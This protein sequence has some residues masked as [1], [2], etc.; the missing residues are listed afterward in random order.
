M[1]HVRERG[2]TAGA[3]LVGALLAGSQVVAQGAPGAA[4]GASGMDAFF[5]GTLQIE[6]P[7]TYNPYFAQRQFSPDH[8]YVDLEDGKLF[9]GTWAI[10]DGKICTTR[11]SGKTF[12]NLGVGHIAGDEWVDKDPYTGNE[13]DF[14][15]TA[16][17]KPLG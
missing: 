1:R 9:H 8:T 3:C 17:R 4:A 2:L 16:V 11:D 13:V 5:V 7:N 15:L 14:T 10:K 6:V 12:C